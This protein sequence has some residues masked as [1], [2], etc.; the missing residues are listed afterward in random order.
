MDSSAIAVVVQRAKELRA[1][2]MRKLEGMLAARLRVYFL[3]LKSTLGALL[4][5]LSES[6]RPLFSWNPE[7]RHS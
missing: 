2:E 6:M 7:R 4:H 1:E 3:L 5:T